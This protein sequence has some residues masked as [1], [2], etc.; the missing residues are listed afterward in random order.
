M[1]I[2]P[3]QWVVAFS[4]SILLH[5]AALYWLPLYQVEVSQRSAE[6]PFTVLLADQE[7]LEHLEQPEV[8]LSDFIPLVS[9]DESEPLMPE[10]E[11][12]VTLF[13]EVPV[14]APLD[15]F[16]ADSV[17]Q[18]MPVESDDIVMEVSEELDSPLP[19][20]VMMVV[21]SEMVELPDSA[22][23]TMPVSELEPMADLSQVI[24]A[25]SE[26]PSLAFE[27][28]WAPAES[29]WEDQLELIPPELGD[30]SDIILEEIMGE[31]I[32]FELS[33]F[34]SLPQIQARDWNPLASTLQPPRSDSA[35]SSRSK[36][37]RSDFRGADG[38]DFAY[39]KKMRGK[40]TQ[41]TLYPK[42]VAEENKIEG[43]VVIEFI[44]D[45]K[46]LL[47]ESEIIKSSGHLVLDEAVKRMIDFAQPFEAL[48]ET[49][50]HE[51]VRFAFPVTIKLKK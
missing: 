20:T 41:F 28:D 45:R 50:K 3:Q 5:A 43:R 6:L 4:A 30:Q 35:G 33:S 37:W 12:P 10:M 51:H 21:D 7:I 47:V 40:L 23:I 39:R 19:P 18:M 9:L 13:D 1:V 11:E 38:I 31:Q 27:M 26:V 24:D 42:A 48:P 29:S 2:R 8:L 36:Y 49:V 15:I 17:E 22:E 46:G 25:F 34:D 16:P 14:E 32:E 44:L